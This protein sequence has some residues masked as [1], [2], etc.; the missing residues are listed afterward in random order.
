[1]PEAPQSPKARIAE[2]RAQIAHHDTLYYKKAQPELSDF[3]YD[4]LKEELTALEKDHPELAAAD[5]PSRQ[6]GDDR[7]EGFTTYRH[8]R[9]MLSLDNTYSQAELLEFD[10]RLRRALGIPDTPFSYLVEPKID[11]LA[12]SITYE[13]GVFVRAVTRGNGTEGDEVTRNLATFKSLPRTLKGDHHPPVMEVRGEVYM[14]RAEFNRI[15]EERAANGLPLYMNPRNLTSGTIKQL[16]P[17]EVARRNLCFAIHGFGYVEKAPWQRQSEAHS[18]FKEWGLPVVEA[19]RLAEGPDAVWQQIEAIDNLR[20]TLPY[21][22]DGA[23]VKLDDLRLQEQA[24]YT[25]KSPRWAMA[26][27]FAPEQAA[28]VL[29]KITIQ[30]GRT[31]A[32]TPV[33][34][35]R[36]VLL[37][38]TTVQNA[39]LHNA[40]EIARKDI[41]EG[42]WV[43]VQKAGEI[44][45][46][47]ITVLTD[48]RPPESQPY[49]FPTHCP[50]CSTKA[51]RA[52]GEVVWRCPNY[53]CPPKLRRRLEH[54]AAKGSLDI[55]GL[56][57]AVI[58]Q[59]VDRSLASEPADFYK[60]TYDQ[61]R[62]L[63]KFADK[64]ARNLLT[65]IEA[66]KS[67]DLW[68]VI[69]GLGVPDVGAQT[70]KDLA[71]RFGSL[72]ALATATT[73]DLL[74]IDGI[75]TEVAASIRLYFDT[76]E[77]KNIVENLL[78]VGLNPTPPPGASG[79]SGAAANPAVFGKAFVLTGT[80]PTLSRDEAAA[81]IEAAGGRV[82]SSV[83]KK[84]DYVVAGESAG[85]KLTKAEQLGIKILD[86]ES[87]HSLLSST[88]HPE[89]SK[90]PSQS[91]LF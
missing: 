4:L 47:V 15:N 70:A 84:T 54:F 42:D 18:F 8:R 89:S 71:R 1:M 67:A 12:I 40:D 77:Q 46:Q 69:N 79:E 25:S 52:D 28:T 41:R 66:S 36:P 34:N 87:L 5:S 81:L 6:V 33:A 60:L 32:L 91:S 58:Q 23:V 68:R 19:A 39:S 17:A 88:P 80:L 51:V 50:E 78:A 44:I 16:D 13:N 14:T 27:K 53:T 30:V 55:E 48:K 63:E 74:K 9:P 29:E 59:L 76:P 38:G 37:A 62:T 72:Q 10:A 22:T 82:S 57:E 11:G 56:G 64:S 21:E 35:L 24:G 75:G 61:L 31:G 86:E 83:S 65:A 2:L 85:S 90:T 43:V 49:A 45:P 73:D 3:E 20:H 26:Y 7:L